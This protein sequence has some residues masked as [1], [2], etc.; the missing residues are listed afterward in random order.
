[1]RSVEIVLEADAANEVEK[2]VQTY[3]LKNSEARIAA[4]ANLFIDDIHSMVKRR[5]L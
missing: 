2:K 3:I 5:R 4:D 1:M